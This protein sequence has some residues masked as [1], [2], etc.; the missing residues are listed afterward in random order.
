MVSS[1]KRKTSF[2]CLHPNTTEM[3][4]VYSLALK[5]I[6]ILH[7]KYSTITYLCRNNIPIIECI[8]Q[9]MLSTVFTGT[10]SSVETSSVQIKKI[11]YI[12]DFVELA[13]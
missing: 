9:N 8:L 1:L 6:K 11:R 3:K 7:L 12:C 10:I 13:L 4:R 5:A 2:I